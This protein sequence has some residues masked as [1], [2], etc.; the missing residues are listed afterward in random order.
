[1]FGGS[2]KGKEQDQHWYDSGKFSEIRQGVF[3]TFFKKT[4]FSWGDRK[5]LRF[6]IVEK[7]ALEWKN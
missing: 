3:P 2:P 4:A 7:G 5:F 6:W 1:M